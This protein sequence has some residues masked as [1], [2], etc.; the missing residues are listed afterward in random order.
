MSPY[1]FWYV[2]SP[3]SRDITTL[4]GLDLRNPFAT[5]QYARARRMLDARVVLFAEGEGGDIKA[6]ALGF[7]GGSFLNRWLEVTS[8]P[9]LKEPDTFWDGVRAYCRMQ[10]VTRLDLESFASTSASVPWDWKEPKVIRERTEW[11]VD[12]STDPPPAVSANHR[13]SIAKATRAGVTVAE[14]TD[15]Q[16]A[17]E[18]A[19]L[20]AASMDRRA[21]RGES[22][23]LV[24]SYE[25]RAATALLSSGAGRLYQARHEGQI[26]SS[27]MILL[28]P[29]GAY[30][31]SA[32]TTPKGMELGASALLVSDVIRRLAEEGV[33]VFNLGGAGDESPGLQRFKSSFGATP[34][35]L[36]AGSYD[37]S[38]PWQRKARI[39]IRLLRNPSTLRRA[40]VHIDTFGVF[41]ASATD[42]VPTVDIPSELVKLDNDALAAVIKQEPEYE[43]QGARVLRQGFNAAYGLRENGAFC[44]IAWLIDHERDTHLTE[45]HVRLQSGEAEITHCYTPEKYRG[46]GVYARA[47][48][49]LARIAFAQGVKHVYMI[50]NAANL[51]SRKGIVRAG[52]REAGFIWHVQLR[53]VFAIT[54]RGHRWPRLNA[55]LVKLLRLETLPSE[56]AIQRDRH[57]AD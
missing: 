22:V 8:I 55:A 25:V 19:L 42:I 37:V 31:Q 26:V 11:L 54:L 23:S 29:N 35:A 56:Y 57:V 38:L 21:S 53:G 34:V 47:I 12:L 30:Y 24:P 44:H 7:L 46:T 27:L 48:R 2:E 41:I 13:R 39:G 50:T 52:L 17:G 28:A 10:R 3:T 49:A 9:S 40:I 45:R 51:P 6:G 43:E 14:A 18:H 1:G 36:T 32:G 33:Q 16:A 4:Q 5:P 15:V 20:M